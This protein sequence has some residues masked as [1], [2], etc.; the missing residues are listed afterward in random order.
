MDVRSLRCCKTCM[1]EP[2]RYNKIE[3]YKRSIYIICASDD[4]NR[5]WR[6]ASVGI[7]GSGQMPTD[8]PRA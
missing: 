2:E 6:E 7:P 8:T 3:W 5:G 4:A 1:Y